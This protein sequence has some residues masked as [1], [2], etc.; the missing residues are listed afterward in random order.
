[1]II[2]T[3]RIGDG[4][5]TVPA[6]DG[7]AWDKRQRQNVFIFYKKIQRPQKGGKTNDEMII[8]KGQVSQDEF[9]L[10][11]PVDDSTVK[12]VCV[13]LTPIRRDSGLVEKWRRTEPSRGKRKSIIKKINMTHIEWANG[14]AVKRKTT[15]WKRQQ[16]ERERGQAE[17]HSNPSGTPL[18]LGA[19]A[20]LCWRLSRACER[21][22]RRENGDAVITPILLLPSMGSLRD[23]I[24]ERESR[25]G[26]VNLQ[27][28]RH[29]IV[30]G[31]FPRVAQNF[32][33]THAKQ[34]EKQEDNTGPWRQ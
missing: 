22:S 5:V 11:L 15:V 17:C 13:S 7:I 29:I 10:I 9:F 2:R 30:D 3:G 31:H 8:I 4:V 20:G 32:P 33:T 23:N 24:K 6:N 19:R 28:K 12:R 1:M 26:A 21:P 34:N 18:V 27:R 16:V 14:H 25:S